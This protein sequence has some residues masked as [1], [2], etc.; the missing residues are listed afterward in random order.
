MGTITLEEKRA[1][2]REVPYLTPEPAFNAL[3]TNFFI[4]LVR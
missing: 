4:L 1:I 3:N 2:F